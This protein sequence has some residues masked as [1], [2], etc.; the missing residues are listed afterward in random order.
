MLPPLQIIA[1]AF[2]FCT[3]CAINTHLF[4]LPFKNMDAI[5]YSEKLVK[6]YKQ[7]PGFPSAGA[8]P[9]PKE[10]DL[11]TATEFETAVSDMVDDVP[12]R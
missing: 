1:A 3:L 10:Y 5:R 6:N 11:D 12:V 8:G 7:K 9:A 4:V 2:N